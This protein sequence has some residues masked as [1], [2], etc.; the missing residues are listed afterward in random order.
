[1]NKKDIHN[2][3]LNS[4]NFRLL[5]LI[6][7]IIKEPKIEDITL[8]SYENGNQEFEIKINIYDEIVKLHLSYSELRGLKFFMNGEFHLITDIT[9]LCLIIKKNKGK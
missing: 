3:I 1:L 2:I 4:P 7:K 6:E 8:L 5:Y 9:L